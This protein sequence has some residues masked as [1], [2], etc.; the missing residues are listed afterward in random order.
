MLHNTAQTT[1]TNVS[2]SL[3]IQN[4][5]PVHTTITVVRPGQSLWDIAEASGTAD[6]PGMVAR[7]AELNDLKGTTIRAGQT[8]EIP[9]A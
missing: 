8:L 1:A 7:I 2:N 6:V 3:F 4:V 5:A 9:A